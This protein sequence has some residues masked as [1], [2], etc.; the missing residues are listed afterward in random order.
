MI[1]GKASSLTYI[2][3]FACKDAEQIV[4]INH[5]PRAKMTHIFRI[6]NDFY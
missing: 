5:A 2:G 6:F 1:F 3:D 4:K